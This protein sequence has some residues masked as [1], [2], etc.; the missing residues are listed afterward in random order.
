LSLIGIPP[1][2]GFF[3]KLYLITPIISNMGIKTLG[4]KEE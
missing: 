2:S 4:I 3:S 1:L